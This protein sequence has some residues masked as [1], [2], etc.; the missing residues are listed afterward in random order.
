MNDTPTLASVRAEYDFLRDAEREV[1]DELRART[2]LAVHDGMSEAEA[3]RV[4]KVDRMTVRAWL[5]K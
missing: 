3:A 1:W 4:A 2:I 5:G